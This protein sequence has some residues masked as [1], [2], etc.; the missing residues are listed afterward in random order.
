MSVYVLF[1][2]SPTEQGLQRYLELG[3]KMFALVQ[4][5]PGFIRAERFKSLKY[6][7]KL[8]SLSE[9]ENLE[10]V[11]AWREH[12]EHVLCQQEGRKALFAAYKITITN[13]MNEYEFINEEL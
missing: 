8:L 12:I 3:A 4:E 5:M 10:S 7:G 2:V 11:Q 13:V 6:E 1:E 9:W